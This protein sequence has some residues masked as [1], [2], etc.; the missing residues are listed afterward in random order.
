[1]ISF[2]VV[3]RKLRI[4]TDIDTNFLVNVQI[5]YGT[6]KKFKECSG[7]LYYYDTTNMKK[8]TTNNQVTDYTFLNTVEK[9]KSYSHRR[10]IKGGD[11]SRILQQ[12]VG[13][14]STQALK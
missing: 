7:G 4:T 14:I 11:T 5:R 2:S 8:K 9:I 6:R 10:E 12:L 1:M 13:W 3:A